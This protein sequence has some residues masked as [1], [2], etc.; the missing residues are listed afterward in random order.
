VG[1]GSGASNDV[2]LALADNANIKIQTAGATRLTVNASNVTSTVGM[3]APYL[4]TTAGVFNQGSG[5]NNNGTRT[6]LSGQYTL[7]I[8]PATY[9]H[10]ASSSSSNYVYITAGNISQGG[11]AYVSI[12]NTTG[13]YIADVLRY[14]DHLGTYKALGVG[15]S[16]TQGFILVRCGDGFIAV[17]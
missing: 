10:F 15:A 11:Q 6:T 14:P 5:Y 1:K 8:E 3:I 13:G 7:A 9:H 2:E 12:Q 16:L 4:V 17:G